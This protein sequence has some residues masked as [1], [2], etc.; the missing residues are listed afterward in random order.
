MDPLDRVLSQ[1]RDEYSPD[2]DAK[3]RVRVALAA[4][5]AASAAVGSAQLGAALTSASAGAAAGGG[6]AGVAKGLAAAGSLLWVKAVVGVG[7]ATALTATGLHYAQRPVQDPV[8]TSATTSTLA[9]VAPAVSPLNVEAA[10]AAP[11]LL[12]Q[13]ASA[14]QTERVRAEPQPQVARAPARVPQ[15]GVR[16]TTAPEHATPATTGDSAPPS[17]LL[18]ELSL[19]RSASQALRAGRASQAQRALQ[20]HERRF[21]N[22]VLGHERR[23]LSVLANC[24]DGASPQ[25]RSVAERFV[26]ATPNSPLA[27]S[28]RKRCLQ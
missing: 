13:A 3:R 23:G 20:E 1:V 15:R 7:L 12:P 6:S 17:T 8:T 11:D 16:V 19:L 4:S 5:L 14:P 25:E 9:A 27:E 2:E 24:S 10:T 22:T 26:A 28:I 21:P 18:E